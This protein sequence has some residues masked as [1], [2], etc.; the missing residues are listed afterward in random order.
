MWG[1]KRLPS[2]GKRQ[3]GQEEKRGEQG[4]SRHEEHDEKFLAYGW[5]FNEMRLGKIAGA[6][7]AAEA[8]HPW[9][10]VDVGA[11]L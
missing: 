6:A 8:G 9:I 10:G 7:S 5:R 3:R 4:D 11:E 2:G 1:R